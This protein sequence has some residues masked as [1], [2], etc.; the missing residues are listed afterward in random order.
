MRVEARE[1]AVGLQP[2][3]AGWVPEATRRPLELRLV[4]PQ[5]RGLFRAVL[6]NV[7]DCEQR[8]VNKG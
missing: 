2:A 7:N 6:G 4:G 3:A 8:I 1:L 5:R